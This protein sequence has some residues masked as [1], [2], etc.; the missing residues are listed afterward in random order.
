MCRICRGE[1]LK[2][3]RVFKVCKNVTEIIKLPQSLIYF[4]CNDCPLLTTLPELPQSLTHFN[5]GG[6]LLTTLPELPQSLTYLHCY[7]CPLLTTLPEIPKS[8]INL[9]C[10]KCTSLIFV[11]ESAL[12]FISSDLADTI[13]NNYLKWRHQKALDFFSSKTGIIYEELIRKTWHPSR[14]VDWCWDIEEVKW[15]KTLK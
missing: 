12:R 11:P 8:L 3:L 5:C 10:E 7:N 2:N 13:T 14:V 9:Y 6:C 4:N 1:S 15:F